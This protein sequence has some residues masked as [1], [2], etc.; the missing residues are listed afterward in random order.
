MNRVPLGTNAVEAPF[1]PVSP[2]PE[3]I[4]TRRS[5]L[6]LRPVSGSLLSSAA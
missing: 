2:R 3:L 5:F 1:G 4:T 6:P